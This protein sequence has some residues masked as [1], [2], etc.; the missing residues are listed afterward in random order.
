VTP[1]V[2]IVDTNVVVAGLL[3]S[4]P[5]SPVS[6]LLDGMLA[7]RFAYL[8]SPALLGEYRAVLLRPMIARRHGL[9]AREVDAILTELAANARWREPAAS[10]LPA[11]DPGDAHLWALLGAAEAVLVTGDQLLLAN[12][13]DGRSV[14]STRSFLELLGP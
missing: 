13:P 10:S 7:G 6:R 3:S 8:L 9:A 5:A 1:P 4:D 11:P 2:A 14:L 12:P